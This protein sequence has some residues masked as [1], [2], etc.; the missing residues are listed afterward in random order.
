[1]TDSLPCSCHDACDGVRYGRGCTSEPAP[2]GGYCPPYLAARQPV[3]DAYIVRLAA[4]IPIASLPY[5]KPTVFLS[6]RHR[7]CADYDG[8]HGDPGDE[9]VER[10]GG[11]R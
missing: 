5:R 10:G 7:D 1:M 2:H 8:R 11:D 3:G 4:P 6:D 9:H